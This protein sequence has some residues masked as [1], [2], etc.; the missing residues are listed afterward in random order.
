MKMQ[1]L[2]EIAVDMGSRCEVESW[3]EL[4]K[5]LLLSIPAPDRAMFS[6]RDPE[7]KKQTL[8]SIERQI[9]DNYE[10]KTGIRL[11]VPA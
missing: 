3:I 8:N 5:I 11:E 4:K 2:M 6:T 9:V 10:K 7:T 1:D